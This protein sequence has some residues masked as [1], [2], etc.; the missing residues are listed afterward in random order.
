MDPLL[1]LHY[2]RKA[3][4]LI[5]EVVIRKHEDDVNLRTTNVE[6][7]V[8]LKYAAI[9]FSLYRQAVPIKYIHLAIIFT[10]YALNLQEQT[11]DFLYISDIKHLCK[12]HFAFVKKLHFEI[13]VSDQALCS[14]IRREFFGMPPL[15]CDK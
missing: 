4:K 3:D 12:G 10:Y 15:I 9:L 2:F 14:A 1:N 13:S 6:K 7:K 8:L 11:T 5:Q